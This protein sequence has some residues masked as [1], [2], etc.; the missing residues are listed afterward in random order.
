LAVAAFMGMMIF[1]AGIVR[2]TTDAAGV[3]PPPVELPET[4]E[5]LASWTVDVPSG[6]GTV[7]GKVSARMVTTVFGR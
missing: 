4:F 3:A 5:A 6:A 1:M 7:S 2:V